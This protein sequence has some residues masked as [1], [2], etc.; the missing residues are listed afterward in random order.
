M[1]RLN[2]LG[3]KAENSKTCK[4]TQMQG[5]IAAFLSPGQIVI[6]DGIYGSTGLIFHDVVDF[7]KHG[8]VLQIENFV[9]FM[10]YRSYRTKR[11][12]KNSTYF[13]CLFIMA[14]YL[15]I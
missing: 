7:I 5:T 8:F 4:N 9:L 13:F 12:Q 10:Y 14:A 3:D 1:G 11:E 6:H 2:N 15:S